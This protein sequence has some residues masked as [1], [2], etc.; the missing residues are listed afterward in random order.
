MKISSTEY[1]GN[2][3][4][5]RLGEVVVLVQ[6]ALSRI[7]MLYI[8]RLHPAYIWLKQETKAFFGVA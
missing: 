1:F 5:A 8:A 4:I 2:A 3:K 7:A 6:K